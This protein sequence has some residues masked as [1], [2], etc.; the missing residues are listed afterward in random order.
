MYFMK[1]FF[2]LPMV[3]GCA[4]LTA[5]TPAA[6][7]VA[8]DDLTLSVSFDNTTEADLANGRAT[9]SEFRG[10]II[11]EPGLA[12][13]GLRIGKDAGCT[14]YDCKDNL[15]FDNPG[16][17]VLWFKADNWHGNSGSRV[18]LWGLGN[19]N[20]HIA[21]AI[22]STP[23]DV[24]PCRR[25]LEFTIFHSKK[26]RNVR[27]TITPPA[28]VKICH[29][30][31]MV[32]VAWAGEQLF[33]SYDGAPYKA[34]KLQVPLSNDEFAHCSRFAIGVNAGW[35]FLVDDFR[36][37]GKKLSDEELHQIWENGKTQ[38]QA[39]VPAAQ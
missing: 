34:F 11:Y 25:P 2:I 13:Q 10:R 6:A 3:L 26:R 22:A 38:V 14:L 15:D 27:Y 31:H 21:L 16:T 1:K 28:L 5:E 17:I 4:V 33:L 30:W 18:S 8:A 20:G 36:I 35:N 29:G 37:Y 9:H 19:N 24:C 32:S 39:Q 23:A 12:G 7:P